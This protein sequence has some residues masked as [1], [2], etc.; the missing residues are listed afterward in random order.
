MPLGCFSRCFRR[1]G[2]SFHRSSQKSSSLTQLHGNHL[3][4]LGDF[5]SF[6]QAIKLAAACFAYRLVSGHFHHHLLRF[7]LKHD[8]NIVIALYHCWYNLITI[9]FC[10]TQVK[11]MTFSID[12]DSTRL[13]QLASWTSS[14]LPQ[15]WYGTIKPTLILRCISAVMHVQMFR[16]VLVCLH[17]R[18]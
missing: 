11:G 3:W 18:C 6:F 4:M 2:C 9:M 17:H 13:H 14:C 7:W 10:H 8:W 12:P 1:C 5:I 16:G 15:M